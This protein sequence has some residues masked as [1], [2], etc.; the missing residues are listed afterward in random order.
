MQ[1]TFCA[2]V[3]I[4]SSAIAVHLTAADASNKARAFETKLRLAFPTNVIIVHNPTFK[5]HF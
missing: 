4:F 1:L 3:F 2:C 5:V